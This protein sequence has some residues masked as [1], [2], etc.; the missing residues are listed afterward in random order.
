MLCHSCGASIRPNAKFCTNCGADIKVT[1]PSETVLQPI[2]QSTQSPICI[3]PGC[4]TPVAKAGHALCYQHWKATTGDKSASHDDELQ[5]REKF[6]AR[7]RT[8]DGHWVRSKAEMLI[9][10]WLYMANIVHAYERQLPIEEAV[11]C[12]FYLPNGKVY[13]EYWGMERDAKYRAR[14]ATKQAIYRKYN[15]NLIELTDEQIKNLDDYLPRQLLKY[16][17]SIV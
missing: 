4:T 2:S 17:V 16:G 14:K 8:T 3:F 6:P 5:F 12:D 11:Y 9:D 7:H 1:I 15:L 10:N 13:I